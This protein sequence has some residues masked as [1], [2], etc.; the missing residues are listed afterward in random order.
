MSAILKPPEDLPV[1]IFRPMSA[2]DL[3]TIHA[4]EQ[5]AYPFPWSLGNFQDCL[6]SGYSCW[7]M[8]VGGEVVG[9]SIM[10]A[11]VGEGHI[12]N[13]CVRPSWQ[14][15]GLGRHLVRRL[16]ATAP[17]YGV[18]TLYLEVRPS[19]AGALNLYGSLGFETIG[20]RRQYY[21]AA[22]GRE[23]ALVMRLCL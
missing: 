1:P 3:T 10:M 17:E 23:D 20:L 22:Q 2:R 19:N 9:Y 6:E 4:I 15:R 14:G 5:E 11:A 7:V 18:E 21:P 12:L 13:C 8:E 16:L